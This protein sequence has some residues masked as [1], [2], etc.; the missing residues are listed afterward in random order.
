MAFVNDITYKYGLQ[1]KYDALLQRDE[2]TLYWCTDTAK[3]YKGDV[4]YTEAVRFVDKHDTLLTPARNVLYVEPDGA[5]WVFVKDVETETDVWKQVFGKGSASG[6]TIVTVIDENSGDDVVPSAKAVYD[7]FQKVECD[8]I[9]LSAYAKTEEVD[10]K[11]Q[12]Y[13][14]KSDIKNI[15]DQME[16]EVFDKPVGTLVDYREK[17]IRILCPSTTQWVLRTSGEN[18]DASMYYLGFKAY[19]PN[20]DVV[21]F[22]EDLKETIEDEEM[23][24]FDDNE[25]AGIDGYGR[26]YSIVWLP[27]ANYDLTSDTWTYYGSMSTEDKYIGWYYRVDWYN[28]DGIVIASDMIRINLSNEECH[29]AISDAVLTNFVTEEEVEKLNTRIDEL[30]DSVI[31]ATTWSEME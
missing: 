14:L 26:K 11:L 10:N 31:T 8:P 9:D 4:D 22:K 21:S 25:F 15:A 12:N 30:E 20:A 7:L 28:A 23:Y 13:A 24:F 29:Y 16:Y 1:A 2:Q 5:G 19:A 17:E 6:I 3:L 18:S 27:V